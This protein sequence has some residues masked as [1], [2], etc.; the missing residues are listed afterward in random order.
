MWLSKPTP[1]EITEGGYGTGEYVSTWSEPVE[2]LINASPATGDAS[3]SPF[4]IEESYDLSLVSG[5]NRW[6]IEE[7]DR[8]WLSDTAPDPDG[9]LADAYRV[10]RVSPSLDY[11]AFGLARAVGR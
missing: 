7:G 11:V 2:V 9:D 4:G 6:G 1:E 10:N 5:D 3:S 8:M